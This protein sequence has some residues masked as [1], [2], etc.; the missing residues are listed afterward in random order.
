MFESRA[1][2]RRVKSLVFKFWRFTVILLS[3][4]ESWEHTTIW[5][6]I[7][8]LIDYLNTI[9]AGTQNLISILL[10]LSCRVL[11]SRYHQVW[12][13]AEAPAVG[14][15]APHTVLMAVGCADRSSSSSLW[16]VGKICCG[17]AEIRYCANFCSWSRCKR[18]RD[19]DTGARKVTCD[20]CGKIRE[21]SVNDCVPNP[22]FVKLL[23]CEEHQVFYF[24]KPQTPR[25]RVSE[26]E[27]IAHYSSIYW[28]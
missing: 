15:G 26:D 25:N 17:N 20:D 18:W 24:N 2:C 4:N 6:L 11:S 23:T 3:H 19:S 13:V 16:A 1:S 8:W 27:T 5:R 10:M 21:R 14:S 28:A 9:G 12:S 7:D 22:F